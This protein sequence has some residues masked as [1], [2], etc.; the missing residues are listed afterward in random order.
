MTSIARFDT[1]SQPEQQR[2]AYWN[3]CVSGA[4]FPLELD[5]T[6]P[7]PLCASLELFDLGELSL[8]QLRSTPLR[9]RR[10]TR[11]LSACDEA[12]F[13]LTLPLHSCF[14][15]TQRG[16]S[17]RCAPGS[18]VLERSAEPYEFHY[19]QDNLLRV[20]KLPETTLRR[21]VAAPD[22][23]CAL[24]FD[25]SQGAGALFVDYLELCVRRLG[26]LHPGDEAHLGRQLMELLGLALERQAPGESGE[27]AVSAAHL[28]RIER[29]I[30]RHLGDNDLS[31]ASIAVACGISVRYLHRLFQGS[32]RSVQ[33]WIRA[34]RLQACHEALSSGPP[35]LPLGELAYR[36]GF[37][38]QAHF[39]RLFKQ[40]FGVTPGEVRRNR[41]KA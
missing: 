36:W 16:R 13:L 3:Q 10:Q 4:Y 33:E 29:H 15:F 39:S 17:I 6:G 23:L 28:L 2:Q 41:P 22:R 1:A 20:L 38:D 27:S 40:R 25:A 35:N 21:H 24:A 37:A 31:P 7:Q 26:E 19:A 14:E 11:H 8:S 32:G 5:Y 9:Y 34:L 18:F 12:S 30:H